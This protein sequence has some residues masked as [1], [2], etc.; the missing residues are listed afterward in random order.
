[1]LTAV[2][3]EPTPF[4]NGALSHSLR[5]LGQTLMCDWIKKNKALS[6]QEIS[7]IHIL[8]ADMILSACSRAEEYVFAVRKLLEISLQD[9]HLPRC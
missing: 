6:K 2:R 3:F 7:R 1:M 5:P 4:R 8:C 9:L